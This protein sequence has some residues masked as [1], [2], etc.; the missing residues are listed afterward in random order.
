MAMASS[1]KEAGCNPVSGCSYHRISHL[2]M[3]KLFIQLTELELI[4]QLHAL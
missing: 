1:T 2:V 3:K 4:I